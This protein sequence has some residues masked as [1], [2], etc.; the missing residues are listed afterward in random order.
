ME[1]W[2]CNTPE[3]Q[4]NYKELMKSRDHYWKPKLESIREK[5][6]KV[7]HKIFRKINKLWFP[8]NN[9]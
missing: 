3:L 8:M 5:E 6:E 9:S 7:G 4:K 1:S 2:L